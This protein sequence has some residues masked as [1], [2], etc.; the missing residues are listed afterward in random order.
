MSTEWTSFERIKAA[1]EHREPD[2]IPFDLGGSTLT[3]INKK[4]YY[5]LRKYLG[6]KVPASIEDI[7]IDDKMQQL[8][9]VEDDVRDILKCDARSVMPNASDSSPHIIPDHEEDGDIRFT[10]EWGLGWRMPLDGGH[11]FDMYKAPMAHIETYD[12]LKKWKWNDPT[13]PARFVGMREQADKIVFEEK[14]AYLLGR[15]FAGIFETSLWLRGIENFMVDLALNPDFAE[16]LLDIIVEMKLQY[17]EKALEEVGNNVLLVTEAD[18]L[19]AQNGLL[20]SEDMYRKFLKPRHKRIHE[21]IKRK[22]QN[23]VYIFFHCCGAI[24]SIVPDLI[25]SEIDILNPWQV[26]A[27]SMGDTAKFKKEFGKEMTIW[28]GGCDSQRILNM[29]NPLEVR[30]ETKR[31]I[32]DLAPGGGFIF[33]PVHNIQGEVPPENIMAMWETLQENSKY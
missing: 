31:R 6:L 21:F 12:E 18:D 13:D 14:T 5:N 2:R 26:N 15:Q 29:G 27:A 17:W 28:G 19:G 8:A 32:D 3:G 4:A 33:N 7:V 30:E 23:K 25:E 1:V 11:Y 20:I 24:Y 22:A 16:A 9:L 10:D